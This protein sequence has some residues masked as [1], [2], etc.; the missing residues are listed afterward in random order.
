MPASKNRD[1]LM[2]KLV[3]PT[4]LSC[5]LQVVDRF[6]VALNYNGSPPDPGVAERSL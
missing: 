2:F 6:N 1:A 5:A 4:S 3:D